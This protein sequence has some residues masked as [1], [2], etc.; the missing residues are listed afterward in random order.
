[1]RGAGRRRK[2]ARGRAR[3]A[4]S[5]RGSRE[6]SVDDRVTPTTRSPGEWDSERAAGGDLASRVDAN[7]PP[8]WRELASALNPL[9]PASKV[10]PVAR[11]RDASETREIEETRGGRR[12]VARRRES[13]HLSHDV[14]RLDRD[15]GHGDAQALVREQLRHASLVPENPHTRVVPSLDLE[16]TGGRGLHSARGRRD[17]LAHEAGGRRGSL[18]ALLAGH[19]STH[20]GGKLDRGDSS[21]LSIRLFTRACKSADVD[22]T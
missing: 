22:G 16:A 13:T 9:I 10:P 14:A 8:P 18:E 2:G 21:H 7:R 6:A 1:M 19:R 3:A 15:D 4:D 11:R 17:G 20:A 5:G 12:E